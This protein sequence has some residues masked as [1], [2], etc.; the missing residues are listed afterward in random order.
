[1][2]TPHKLYQARDEHRGHVA[3]F[4]RS[5]TCKFCRVE[6]A[7]D[8]SPRNPRLT[9]DAK[10]ARTIIELVQGVAR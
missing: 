1:M 3:R 10:S 7:G 4:I 8:R 6:A 9:Q 5:G 2:R